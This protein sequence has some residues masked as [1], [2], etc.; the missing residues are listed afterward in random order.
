[1]TAQ[2]ARAKKERALLVCVSIGS[3]VGPAGMASGPMRGLHTAKPIPSF[4][5]LLPVRGAIREFGGPC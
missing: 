5:S 2:Q 4:L 1:M 3:R